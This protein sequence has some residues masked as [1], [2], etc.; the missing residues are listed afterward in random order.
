MTDNEIVK[1]AEICFN[2][3]DCRDCPYYDKVN[4]GYIFKQELLNF[5]HRKKENAELKAKIERLKKHF[6]YSTSEEEQLQNLI[7]R[8]VIDNL[9]KEMTE[10]RKEDEGK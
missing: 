9:V 10:Q 2:Y 1:A 4:C 7:I 6:S 5:I 8:D 3:G